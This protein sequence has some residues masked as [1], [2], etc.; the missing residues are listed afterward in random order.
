M[1]HISNFVYISNANF[2]SLVLENYK[3][4]KNPDSS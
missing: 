3:V 2:D 4:S 1:T